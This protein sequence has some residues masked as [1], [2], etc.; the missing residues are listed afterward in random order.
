MRAVEFFLIVII[1]SNL[2]QFT[3]LFYFQKIYHTFENTTSRRNIFC[4]TI[5]I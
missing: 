2:K 1:N 3:A 5:F 4:N